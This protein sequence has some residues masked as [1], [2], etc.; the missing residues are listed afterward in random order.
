MMLHSPKSIWF[1][2]A[3]TAE[4]AG[5]TYEVKGTTTTTVTRI[6][7]LPEDAIHVEITDNK[8]T[9]AMSVE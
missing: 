1:R 7:E 3:Y 8:P 5:T 4:R 2:S 9:S 6:V